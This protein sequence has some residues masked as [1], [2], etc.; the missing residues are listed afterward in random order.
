MRR[1]ILPLVALSLSC[2]LAFNADAAER[3]RSS[4]PPPP[5]PPQFRV[6]VATRP[7]S[8]SRFVNQVP[9]G[10]NIGKY[11]DDF[12]CANSQ[13][14]FS[15]YAFRG[16]PQQEYAGL[17]TAEAQAAGY[18]I[19]A[20]STDLFQSQDS[21][22]PELMVGAV[23]T[24][25][26][27]R[28]RD[29]TFIVRNYTMEATISVDWQVFDPLEKKIVFRGSSQGISEARNTQG[30]EA[31][32]REVARAAFREAAKA[33]LMNPE[34]V[35]ALKDP[36]GGAPPAGNELFPEATQGTNTPAAS[37]QIARL[38]LHTKTFQEQFNDL[39]A[40]VVTV[41]AGPG[42][43]SGFY[44]ADGFLLTN[45]HVINGYKRVKIRF[46]GGREIDGEVVNTSGKRDIALIKTESVGLP[47]LPLQLDKP[48]VTSQTFVIG[49]PLG[50]ENEGTISTG[51]V[52]GFRDNVEG[53]MIQSDVGIT[54]GNSGGPMFDAKG[55]V[56]AVAVQ[57]L[58]DQ[59]GTPTQVKLFIPIADALKSLGLEFAPAANVAGH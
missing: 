20:A 26:T 39:R 40:Q 2:L 21:S 13:Q 50:A 59:Y 41:L 47:G 38:P 17:F 12:L 36:N 28:G 34:F 29:Q 3:R 8:M 53:P 32:P 33:I 45:E 58:R 19:A 35:A 54:H 49:S 4:E 51:I 6:D 25:F 11:C 9:V 10:A 7:M 52:S 24:S 42:T 14:I 5:P 48:E 37:P 1:K 23:V 57:A 56:T 15:D 46:F 22:K 30:P 43:G 31:L 55:N 16:V 18:N 27:A 44:I